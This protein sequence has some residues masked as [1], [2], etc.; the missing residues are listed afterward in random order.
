MLE[1]FFGS[2]AR[3]KL[4]RL[5][6]RQPE[7]VF[8]L[9]ELARAAGLPLN[10]VRREV[11]RLSA[12]ELLQPV[13]GGARPE[14]GVASARVKYFRLN[15]EALVYP[16]L[17]ALLAKAERWEEQVFVHNLRERGGQVKLLLLSGVFTG[18]PEAPTDLLIVGRLKPLAITRLIR[19]HEA[20]TGK[21]IR[22][23]LLTEAEF[24]DRRELGDKFLYGA[25]ES[26]HLMAVNEYAI[27]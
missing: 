21:T 27:S 10:A 5:L 8:Y 15:T 17:A 7:R 11:L 9:R 20:A 23:T 16:E 12:V 18:A 19:A 1:H 22:Y 25:L 24:H 6:F 26:K 14:G 4:L 3:V 13:S 2:T